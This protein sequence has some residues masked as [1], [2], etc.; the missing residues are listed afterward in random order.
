MEH[1]KEMIAGLNPAQRRAA[2]TMFGPY[3][4]VAGAGSGK[5]RVLT[6]RVARILDIG[7]RP[8][9]IF[10]ATFTN[11]AATEMRERLE[12]IVGEE[13][14]SNVWMNTFHSLC[15][16]I[17]RRDAGLLGYPVK[18][19]R[20]NFLVLDDEESKA[21]LQQVMKEMK[22]DLDI[23]D[24]KNFISDMK[25]KM[26]APADSHH[27]TTL[28][29]LKDLYA[30]YQE[31]LLEQNLMDFDDIIYRTV[32]LLRMPE[33]THWRHH[34]SFVMADEFQDT[35]MAQLE[36]LFHLS[37]GFGNLFVVGDADQSVYAFRGADV[38]IILNLKKYFP[39]LQTILLEQNYRST[40]NIVNA[41]NH[42]IK[43]NKD[44]IDKTCFT[45]KDSGAPITIRGL[46]NDQQEAAFVVG[47]I[48]ARQRN[49]GIPLE[50]IYILYRA[51]YLSANIE[52]M[53]QRANLPY[54]MHK[55]T[56][57]RDR[58]EVKDILAW[59]RVLL[60]PSDE[61][62]Y[63]RIIN[64]P[65]RGIGEK[66]LD[67]FFQHVTTHQI[68]VE[69]ALMR[70][71]ETTLAPRAKKSLKD[72]HALIRVLRDD[73]MTLSPHQA[74][75]LI[76][77]RTGLLEYHQQ[78]DKKD[79]SDRCENI[80]ELSGIVA[81]FIIENEGATLETFIEDSAMMK[82][83]DEEAS[84]VQ[85]MTIHASKGLEAP[86]VYVIG[87]N[88]DVFP[89][90]R[91]TSVEE[92][93]EERRLAYVAITRAEETLTLTYAHMRTQNGSRRASQESKFILEIPLEYTT[94]AETMTQA[95][96]QEFSI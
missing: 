67:I 52:Q 34:F 81:A 16:K 47:D 96:E 23:R 61:Q 70:L 13:I 25:S 85:L 26:I 17:L 89:S 32:E 48:I 53:L 1:I 38:N 15:I 39:K 58:E 49:E 29:T 73:I 88:K 43:H 19:R 45:S 74:I 18:D 37:E 69:H 94:D 71:D 33:G 36:L 56:A 63:R 21:I 77:D 35:N 91:S 42:L 54:H 82:P 5:T 93:A 44:R 95:N 76:A 59:L 79:G 51:S 7:T 41:A 22:C 92:E 9:T 68:P 78:K 84:G 31:K 4:V 60:R 65:A 80:G 90:Y 12:T 83:V 20:A 50:D 87:M 6:T 86:H 72:F 75:M 57:F 28:H 3:L 62:A 66:T 27:H 55:G 46:E 64:K 2:L 8:S 14:A 11:K 24:V 40:S 30:T 10:V